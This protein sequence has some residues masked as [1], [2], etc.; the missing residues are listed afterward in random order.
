MFVMRIILITN[1]IDLPKEKLLL[2]ALIEEELVD[3]HFRKPDYSKKE[4][5]NYLSSF[6]EDI[7][8][9][10][11]T[12]QYPELAIDLRLKGIHFTGKTKC[13]I[14]QYGDYSGSK[15]ISTH[16][17]EEIINQ[18]ETFNYY[19][20]SPIFKS[21]SKQNYGGDTFD[22]NL[23]EAFVKQ[24]NEKEIIALGGVSQN[25]ITQVKQMGFAGV[26]LL[27]SVWN[28]FEESNDIEK[29][30]KHI[31][32]IRTLWQDERCEE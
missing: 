31:K 5:E 28:L 24:Q 32:E 18:E 26:A 1:S 29:V 15:S 19:F 2:K 30:K 9:K 27:G 6:N 7:R 3:I 25:N 11:V 13:S 17:F 21:I 12:H 8:A 4:A 14:N 20:L 10:I 22:F 16:S 23:L